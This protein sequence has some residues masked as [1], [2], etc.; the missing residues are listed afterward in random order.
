MCLCDIKSMLKGG[1]ELL[2]LM[3]PFFNLNDKCRKRTVFIKFIYSFSQHSPFLSY[4]FDSC[5]MQ[6]TR[7][8]VGTQ[9]YQIYCIS[10]LNCFALEATA[11]CVRGIKMSGP[12]WNQSSSK[13][14]KDISEAPWL[15]VIVVNR[16]WYSVCDHA[17]LCFSKCVFTIFNEAF[18]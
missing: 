9:R 8:L 15:S 7:R 2:E 6:Q 10:I 12:H 1:K 18:K 16:W 3:V 11:I 4:N 5:L 13:A 17:F 14:R